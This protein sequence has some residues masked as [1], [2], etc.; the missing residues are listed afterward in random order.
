M[1]FCPHLSTRPQI[2]FYPPCRFPPGNE[3]LTFGS[4]MFSRPLI[5]VTSS[6]TWP[7]AAWLGLSRLWPSN[8]TSGPAPTWPLPSHVAAVADGEVGCVPTWRVALSGQLG[9]TSLWGGRPGDQ[10]LSLSSLL[11]AQLSSLQRGTWVWGSGSEHVVSH[12]LTG[13]EWK[14]CGGPLGQGNHPGASPRPSNNWSAY[15]CWCVS[16]E[17]CV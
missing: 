16:P 14:S 17:V 1:E 3:A 5:S 6:H 10:S 7:Q 4:K 9:E 15:E 8:Q 12:N 2:P 13:K 11:E